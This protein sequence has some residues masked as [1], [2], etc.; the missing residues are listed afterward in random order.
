MQTAFRFTVL[1][2]LSSFL[3]FFSQKFWSFETRSIDH[4]SWETKYTKKIKHTLAKCTVCEHK[5]PRLVTEK[6]CVP[7]ID[8]F[9]QSPYKCCSF[10]WVCFH[11]EFHFWP[12]L[13]RRLLSIEGWIMFKRPKI[14]TTH[15]AIGVL[16]ET[17]GRT[18]TLQGC[19]NFGSH[20]IIST[21]ETVI[22]EQRGS[23]SRG[24]SGGGGGDGV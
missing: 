8:F 17:S 22:C 19:R 6:K 24:G 21:W 10:A 7:I 15:R 18:R 14:K 5:T 13:S 16:G 3:A 2:F 20:M 9:F 23:K 11:W 12:T 1:W 4:K